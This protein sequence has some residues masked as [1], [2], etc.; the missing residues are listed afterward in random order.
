MG[1]KATHNDEIASPTIAKGTMP[2]AWIAAAF[3]L[4]Y[5]FATIVQMHSMDFHSKFL[6]LMCLPILRW[7]RTQ[8]ATAPQIGN[9]YDASKTV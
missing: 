8:E 6:Q 1:S 2:A 7:D 9:E 4:K 5:L 3:S